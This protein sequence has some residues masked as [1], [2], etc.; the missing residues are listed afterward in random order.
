MESGKVKIWWYWLYHGHLFCRIG[1]MI[2]YKK[3][4]ENLLIK[5]IRENHIKEEIKSNCSKEQKICNQSPK[6]KQNKMLVNEFFFV[7]IILTF[8]CWA[9]KLKISLIMQ[10][11]PILN[12]V[13]FSMLWKHFYFLNIQIP[14][15]ISLEY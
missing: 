12:L 15:L 14:Y 10:Q 13:K 7:N 3:L 4:Q 1:Y 2:L 8:K 11:N 9:K 5:R 6:L